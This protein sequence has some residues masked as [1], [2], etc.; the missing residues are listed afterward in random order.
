MKITRVKNFSLSITLIIIFLIDF[1]LIVNTNNKW[2]ET[3]RFDRV[4]N[5]YE[6]YRYVNILK[7]WIINA[8][9]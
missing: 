7:G 2:N 8:N 9:Q 5:Y 1:G 3:D 4:Y 6:V